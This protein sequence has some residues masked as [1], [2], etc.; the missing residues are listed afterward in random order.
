MNRRTTFKCLV[1]GAL[2]ALGVLYFLLLKNNAVVASEF[3]TDG[4]LCVWSDV[5]SDVRRSMCEREE[6]VL[7]TLLRGE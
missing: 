7:D 1:V 4:D 2:G 3:D 5:P 6:A